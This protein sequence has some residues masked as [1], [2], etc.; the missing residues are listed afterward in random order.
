[1][2]SVSVLSSSSSTD[3]TTTTE[4]QAH[5]K[6][7]ASPT[8]SGS[9]SQR[10]TPLKLRHEA[11]SA[12]PQEVLQCKESQAD[13]DTVRWL[14]GLGQMWKFVSAAGVDRDDAN[15]SSFMQ[16]VYQSHPCSKDDQLFTHLSYP[17]QTVFDSVRVNISLES[18]IACP[19]C[20]SVFVVDS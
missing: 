19:S 15:L 1:V 5:A 7:A 12:N 14:Q 11:A 13:F 20:L 2:D 17:W 4:S 16:A 18:K 8:S 10:S 6:A 9:S 3:L